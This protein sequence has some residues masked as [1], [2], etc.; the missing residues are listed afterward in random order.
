[1]GLKLFLKK[2]EYFTTVTGGR[3]TT[4]RGATVAGWT[5]G[6]QAVVARSNTGGRERV[7][8]RER[9]RVSE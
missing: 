8:E 6:L 9:E 7:C 3:V 2:V 1:M 4:G 5:L